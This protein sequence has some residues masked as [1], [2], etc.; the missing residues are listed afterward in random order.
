MGALLERTVSG[1]TALDSY[2]RNG[3]VVETVPLT[4]RLADPVEEKTLHMTNADPSRR[5][6]FTT[7]GNPT[8]SSRRRIRARAS[9]SA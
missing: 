2:V 8:S 4:E 3:G 7:L 1:L 9:P 5:P 6:T